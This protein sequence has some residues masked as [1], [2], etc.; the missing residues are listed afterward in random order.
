MNIY[1]FFRIIWARRSIILASMVSTFVL[2]GIVLLFI[3]AHYKAESRVMLDVIKP[4]P[5]TG[6]VM[7]TTFLRAYTKTQIELVQD[8]QVARHVVDDLKWANDPELVA[9]YHDRKKSDDRDFNRWAAQ[10]V[11]DGTKAE[12]IEGS[13]ILEISYTGY[14]PEKAKQVADAVRKAYMDSS[15]QAR[16]EAARRNAD[17]YEAQAAKAKADLL[18]AETAEAAYERE[19]GVLLQDNKVD[20]DSARLAALVS[21]GTAPPIAPTTV[22]S[23]PSGV[24]LGQ[25]DAEIAQ[26][27][28][29]LG[30]N[31]PQLQEME[32]RRQ[33]LA[34]QADQERKALLATAGAVQGASRVTEG[35]VEAQKSKVMANRE[36]VEKLRLLQDDVDLRSD[37]YNKAAARAAELRQEADV[38]ETE[39]TPLGNAVTPQKPA[40]PNV[41]LVLAGSIVAGAGLGVVVGI[42]LELIGRKVRSADDLR[43]AADAPVLAIVEN[44]RAAKTGW[45]GRLRGAIKL[46]RVQRIRTAKA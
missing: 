20:V 22:G 24:A 4:D 5:V 44:P 3:P 17:W 34:Q 10:R 13:N 38:A 39:V 43:N 18:Q 32:K 37:Q 15:L 7:A 2:A 8:Y 45:F 12:L 36:K 31:H 27:K 11:I 16:Q 33:V 23:T 9:K 6:Q 42:F 28:K 29:T 19:N 40:W 30:P 46:P 21:Q 41:P 35:L 25:L 26:A 1:Q 14:S